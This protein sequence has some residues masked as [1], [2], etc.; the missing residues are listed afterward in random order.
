MPIK[1]FP[2]DA[3]ADQI[4]SLSPPPPTSQVTEI[5][6]AVRAGG[7][8][9]V[10]NFEHRFGGGAEPASDARIERV[11]PSW[12]RSALEGIDV[13]LRAALELAIENVRTVARAQLGAD[14]TVNLDQG[15][16]VEYR[17]LPVARVGAYI[18]GGRGSYPSTAVMCLT[19]AVAAGVG[20]VCA[21]S[22]PRGDGN[23]D[24]AVAAVC[25][26]LEVDELYAIGGAQAVAALALGTETI[27]PVDV[28]VG[29]GNAWVQEAKRQLVGRIGID[30]V[31]GPSELVVVAQH[32]ADAEAIALDLLAQAEHGPD[33]L[34]VLISADPDL[35][36]DVIARAE[37]IGA[38]MAVVL[39]EDLP[40]AVDLAD[41]IAPEHLQ[42]VADD[43]TANEL[44][45]R[46]DRAGALF[47]GA[48]A[49]TAFGDY[50]VGS[51]HVLPTGG[52]AR[53]SGSLSVNT[54][55]RRMARIFI[56]DEAVDRLSRAGAAIARVEGFPVHGRSMEVRRK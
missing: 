24:T 7:D 35:L 40:A 11:D 55:R 27:D 21:V 31:A 29:P 45:E 4:R 37:G 41:A 20:Q 43:V 46:V 3:T 36:D 28:L 39:A 8:R 48:N 10:L 23:V 2:L 19:S 9:A 32:G 38:E 25:A 54:F 42:I 51:N 52:A 18:P 44:A 26:L 22:P 53:Y 56:P 33:S 30:G 14:Q 47:V 6:D 12:M 5:I 15:Q 49:A 50:V 34:V 13:E 16:R 17:D 1:R